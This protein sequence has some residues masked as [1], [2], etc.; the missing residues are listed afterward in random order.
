M[1]YDE[2]TQVVIDTDDLLTCRGAIGEGE[3]ACASLETRFGHEAGHEAPMQLAY[4]THRVPHGGG[5]GAEV[6]SF[7]QGGHGWG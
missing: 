1:A 3:Q 6:E 4:V 2:T 7:T 5:R